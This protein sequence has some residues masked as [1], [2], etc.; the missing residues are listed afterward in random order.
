M[1]PGTG[2][3]ISPARPA[4]VPSVQVPIG[5]VSVDPSPVIIGNTLSVASAASASSSS[6]NGC[7]NAAAA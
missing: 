1:I 6:H 5:A 4:R 7:D 2:S 3:P